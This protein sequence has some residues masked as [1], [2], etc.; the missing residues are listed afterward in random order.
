MRS[1]CIYLQVHS[2]DFS[3]SHIFVFFHWFFQSTSS[4]D[5]LRLPWSSIFSKAH[6]DDLAYQRERRA[7][8]NQPSMDLPL[9]LQ[10][11]SLPRLKSTHSSGS[12]KSASFQEY[13]IAWLQVPDSWTHSPHSSSPDSS[14][15]TGCLSWLSTSSA[16]SS[17]QAYCWMVR[18]PQPSVILLSKC[19]FSSLLA[20]M[21]LLGFFF[22]L[23]T[24]QRCGLFPFLG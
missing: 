6:E 3:W 11:Y 2:S 7:T 17:S 20:L 9:I 4:F 8:W 23:I 13:F 15:R 14:I 18:P 22:N 5:W 19:F 12:L 1:I 21:T 10:R 16:Y 24:P